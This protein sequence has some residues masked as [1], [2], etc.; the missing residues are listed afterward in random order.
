LS[1]RF[2]LVATDLDGTLLNDA[3]EVSPRNRATLARLLEHD[4][5]VVLCTGRPPRGAR[6]IY[7][8]LGL[9]TPLITYNGAVV[10]DA[11][12]NAPILHQPILPELAKRVLMAVRET[13]PDLNVGLEMADEWHLDYLDERITEHLRKTG[14]KWP[15]LGD[16]ETA[17]LRTSP[18]VSKIYFVSENEKR[19]RLDQIL[20]AQGLR[21]LVTLTS[22]GEG[23]IEVTAAGV[24]KGSALTRL[25]EM[26]GI[27]LEEIVAIGDEE[28]DIPALQ[29]CGFGIAMGTAR[30]HVRQAASVVTGDCNHDGWAE[31][32]EKYVLAG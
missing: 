28:N 4:I 5:S 27:G 19:L 12:R 2:R 24:N 25:A 22:S 31:A 21:E 11:E 26:M 32:I 6:A 15:I 13:D 16:L 10:Y 8:S 9:S 3:K 17:V 20:A 14:A 18:G 29:V 23:F 30:E 1:Q 7:D